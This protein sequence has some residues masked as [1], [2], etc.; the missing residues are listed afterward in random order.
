MMNVKAVNRQNM[1]NTIL[2]E[3]DIDIKEEIF[4]QS[5]IISKYNEKNREVINEI[6]KDSQMAINSEDIIIN[7]LK[8][9]E[10]PWYASII[11]RIKFS[12]GIALLMVC[13]GG[14]CEVLLHE[15]IFTKYLL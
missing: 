1:G 5:K 13:I 7:R 14:D 2:F 3:G 6:I 9:L 4:V 12:I 10:E 11:N 8:A 15:F